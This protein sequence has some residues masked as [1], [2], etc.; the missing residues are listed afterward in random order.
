MGLTVLSRLHSHIQL[1][2]EKGVE[3][4]LSWGDDVGGVVPDE[5]DEEEV[6]DNPGTTIGT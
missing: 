2:L 4:V 1:M 3:P 5:P 6:V